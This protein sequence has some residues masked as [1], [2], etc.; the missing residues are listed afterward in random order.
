MDFSLTEDQRMLQQMV[1]DFASNEL[2]PVAAQ[3]D[4]SE[5][6][7]AENIKKMGELGLFGVTIAEKYGGSGGDSMHLLLV[8]EEI[9]R[10]C[11]S[12]STIYL[13]SLSLA[14]YPIY[15]FG[16]EEQKRRFLV[17][18]ARGEKLACFALTESG[19]GSDAAA[20]EATAVHQGDSYLVNGSKIFITN[21]AEADV[22]VLFATT[23]KSLRHRGIVALIVEK[24]T[25]GFSVGKEERKLG[26]RGSSTTELVFEDCRVPAE[27]RLGEEGQGFR[28]AM[29]AIDSSRITVAAQA[30]GIAQGA[31]DASL[32]YAK[33]RQQFGRPIADF[34][35]IQWMLADMATAIDA[36]RFLTY[37]AAYLKDQGLAFVKEAAMAKVFAAEAAM[38]V[39]TKAIQIHG[40]YGYTKDYPVERYFRDAKITEIYEGTSEMQRM[41]VA[42]HLLA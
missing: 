30:V 36:A 27:N 39:T 13:A 42:R 35:A 34:Q 41:T 3:I 1:R 22:I 10:V 37:R 28:I 19:A 26:I 20:L 24:G 14:C 4:E 5:E 21:G 11:G 6:F 7:P 18:L 31:L 15:K 17:P 38:V 16:T 23:D 2:E 8:T 12:T 25:P 9:A 32:G 40:G 33:E 29:G